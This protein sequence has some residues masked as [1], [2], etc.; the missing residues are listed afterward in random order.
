MDPALHPQED[1]HKELI[2]QNHLRTS[3]W[4]KAMLEEMNINGKHEGGLPL[5]LH[6][7]GIVPPPN[8]VEE[9]IQAQ[10]HVQENEDPEVWQDLQRQLDWTQHVLDDLKKENAELQHAAQQSELKEQRWGIE[11]VRLHKTVNFQRE[12]I[13]TLREANSQL[14]NEVVELRALGHQLLSQV[15]QKIMNGFV[16]KHNGIR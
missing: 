5:D 16:A 12:S 3:T 7:H 15:K 11:K 9:N 10:L 13:D 4:S 14:T 1:G 8:G 6:M 2:I